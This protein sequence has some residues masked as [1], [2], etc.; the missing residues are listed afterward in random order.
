MRNGSALILVAMI[1][2]ITGCQAEHVFA[3]N[4][5]VGCVPCVLLYTVLNLKR[6][7]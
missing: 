5:V 1:A 6:D 7:R 4:L 3:G 2:F